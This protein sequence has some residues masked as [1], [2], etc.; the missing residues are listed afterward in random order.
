MH[1]HH[2]PARRAF[3]QRV[4]QLGVAGVAT[5]WALNLAA[6][7]EA[8]AFTAVGVNASCGT[9][10]PPTGSVLQN[11]VPVTGLSAAKGG[12]LNV[13]IDVPASKSKLVIA[14]SG[15][16]ESQR[17]TPEYRE[18]R[19]RPV[20]GTAGNSRRRR[21]AVRTGTPGSG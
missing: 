16:G 19:D 3:L 13:T 15:V 10:P 18:R 2:Q 1:H 12:K 8:A 20:T 9:T 4:G 21:R 11:G 5:P 14:S 17:T 7:G 6:M